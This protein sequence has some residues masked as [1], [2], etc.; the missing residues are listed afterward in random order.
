M[1]M[2]KLK[3][4][5]I[6]S[7]LKSLG[8]IRPIYHSNGVEVPT[9]NILLRHGIEIISCSVG[10]TLIMYSSDKKHRVKRIDHK[11]SAKERSSILPSDVAKVFFHEAYKSDLGMGGLLNTALYAIDVL[12]LPPSPYPHTYF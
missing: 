7:V 10:S 1:S 3:K 11:F 8:T 4:K 5:T 12:P 9:P 6:R 2:A